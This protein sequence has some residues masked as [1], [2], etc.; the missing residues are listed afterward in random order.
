MWVF[1]CH[2]GVS[3]QLQPRIA[4][5]GKW[6]Q[7]ATHTHL[8]VTAHAKA[9]IPAHASN[10][11][12]Q[13]CIC[14]LVCVYVSV[15]EYTIGALS[16]R[17]APVPPAMRN[18]QRRIRAENKVKDRAENQGQSSRLSRKM[19]SWKKTIFNNRQTVSCSL[20]LSTCPSLCLV[21]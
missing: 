4:R 20:T 6:R 3:K 18:I 9:C 15:Y 16:E 14:M 2:S 12:H 7:T 1:L 19:E 17:H 10:T 11:A 8:C 21:L 13:G 5:Q